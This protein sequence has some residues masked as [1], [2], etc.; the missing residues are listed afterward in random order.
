MSH[1][2]QLEAFARAAELQLP[3]GWRITIDGFYT[4]TRDGPELA[5]FGIYLHALNRD[6]VP[7]D[8][9]EFDGDEIGRE[10]LYYTGISANGVAMGAIDV[11]I[12]GDPEGNKVEVDFCAEFNVLTGE[13]TSLQ[14]SLA[15]DD[16]EVEVVVENPPLTVLALVVSDFPPVQRITQALME[17]AGVAFVAALNEGLGV[18][19]NTALEAPGAT[20]KG[21]E[22]GDGGQPE[23]IAAAAQAAAAELPEVGTTLDAGDDAAARS[24]AIGD[25]VAG[26]QIGA[27]LAAAQPAT[28]D[29]TGEAGAGEVIGEIDG[30][31]APVAGLPNIDFLRG[32]G[33]AN[34]AST[35]GAGVTEVAATLSPGPTDANGS[36][37]AD[38][39]AAQ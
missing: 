3:N 26:L 19:E 38:A 24:E 13:L 39:G 20:S 27:E 23:T 34:P 31:A 33:E 10:D 37:S 14:L 16:D 32:M 2:L 12:D 21:T 36:P 29:L 35:Q 30:D 6:G 4:V 25:L 17:R 18:G 9:P 8:N 7:V 22:G 15:N 11:A 5:V 28:L 1:Q